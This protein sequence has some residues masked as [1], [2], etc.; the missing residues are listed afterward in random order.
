MPLSRHS[1][2]GPECGASLGVAN[3]QQDVV[4]RRRHHRDG[5]VQAASLP[6]ADAAS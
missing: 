6:V 5:G 4:Q 2:A 3:A 1:V